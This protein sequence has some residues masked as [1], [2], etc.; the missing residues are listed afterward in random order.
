M[1][2]ASL[3]CSNA[4]GRKVFVSYKYG[5]TNVRSLENLPWW[6]TTKVRDYVDILED[7]IGKDNVYCGEHSDEDLSDKSEDYIWEHLKNKIFPTTVTVVLIS[8]GMKGPNNYDKSQWIPW[9]IRYSLKEYTRSVDSEKDK[10]AK[11]TSH[12][13]GILAVVLP[14]VQGSYSYMIENFRCCSSGCRLLHTDKLFW[15]LQ[16]NM[17]NIKKPN[18][19]ICSQQDTIYHGDCSYISMVKWDDFTRDDI[20][21]NAYLELATM[22]INHKNDYNLHLD[23]D[24]D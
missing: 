21:I 23:V 20:S 12:S 2:V 8:P 14:D 15:I 6:R 13:N 3:I 19:T 16:K 24:K 17:F 22:K 4:M 7:K 1:A 9:E 18:T 10:D 5:D 11:R